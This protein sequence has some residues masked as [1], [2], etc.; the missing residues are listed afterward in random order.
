[1]QPKL[2]LIDG[3]ALAYRM[4]YALPLEAFTTADGEPTNATYGFTRTLVERL[5]SDHPP[6]YFAVSFDLGRTF[7]DDMFAEY[8]GTREKMPDELRVQIGRIK[9]VVR[10]FNIPILELEGYEADDVL[11]TVARQAKEQGVLAHIITGDRDLL[12][13]VDDNTAVELP[14][15]RGSQNPEVFD[16]AAVVDYFGVLPDQVVDWKALVGDTSDNIP[17]VRGVGQKTATRLLQQYGTLDGIYEHIDAVKGAMGK[18]LADG[19]EDAYL[20]YKLA[21]IVTDAPITL[22]LEACL[23]KDFDAAVVLEMFRDLEFRTLSRQLLEHLGDESQYGRTA[24]KLPQPK[25]CLSIA[26]RSSMNWLRS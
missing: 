4:F 3:H 26:K 17:G 18:K 22:D 20:S 9:D 15:R 14:P 24:G 10:A 25:R 23:A 11:G 1:M 19:K 2:V 16:T 8:K 12:Q 7:R 13:L 21:K 5:F 6:E